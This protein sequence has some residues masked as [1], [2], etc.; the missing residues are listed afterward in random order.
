MGFVRSAFAY[1]KAGTVSGATITW[2]S[3]VQL[4]SGGWDV[5]CLADIVYDST[6]EKYILCYSQANDSGGFRSVWFK[7]AGTVISDYNN[8]NQQ[9]IE[10]DN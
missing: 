10:N 2:G 4:S 5:R 8:A 6:T 9:T 3:E 1:A 7:V